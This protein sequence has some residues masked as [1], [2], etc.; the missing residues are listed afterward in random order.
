M[1]HSE[2][3]DETR[4]SRKDVA[5]CMH[6]RTPKSQ[7]RSCGIQSAMSRTPWCVSRASYVLEMI[8]QKSMHRKRETRGLKAFSKAGATVRFLSEKPAGKDERS[9][10]S[11]DAYVE[12]SAQQCRK[13]ETCESF[14]TQWSWRSYR[15]QRSRCFELPHSDVGDCS[16]PRCGRVFRERDRLYV[17]STRGLT[18]FSRNDTGEQKIHNVRRTRDVAGRSRKH[19]DRV[20]RE[21]TR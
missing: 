12:T 21:G 7:L 3:V 18:F 14:F 10:Q 5:V 16:L 19:Q 6:R 15:E 11:L 17:Q 2:N 1:F 20:K 9:Q 13:T 8:P 4:R